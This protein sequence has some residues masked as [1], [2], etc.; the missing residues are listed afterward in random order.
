MSLNFDVSGIENYRE[1]T[2]LE[3]EDGRLEWHP[4]TSAIVYLSLGVGLQRITK[5]NWKKW[6]ARCRLHE[7]AF[8]P[9]LISRGERHEGELY[10]TPEEVQAHIGLSTNVSDKTDAEWRKDFMQSW[11]TEIEWRILKEYRDA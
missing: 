6:F 4:I 9:M 8:G 7:K 3:R 5:S 2:T 1:L 11:T 10:I